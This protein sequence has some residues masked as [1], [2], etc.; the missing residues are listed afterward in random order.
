MI[1][2]EQMYACEIR[3]PW[4]FTEVAERDY[5]WLFHN[6]DNPLSH[7]SNHAV[8]LRLDGDLDAVLADITAFYRRISVV[9]RVY[10]GFRPGEMDLLRPV[11]ERHG[12][13]FDVYDDT[14]FVLGKSS[15]ICPNP[16]VEVR[17]VR[18]TD[19]A[20]ADLLRAAEGSDRTVR[21][22]RRHLEW[23]TFHCLAGYVDGHPVTLGSFD[24]GVACSRVDN[25][26]THPECRG[27]GY[28]SALMHAMVQQY[29]EVSQ[30]PLYMWSAAPRA[31]KIYRRAGFVEFSAD[32][33]GWGA[34]LE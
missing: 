31:M 6:A 1:S 5:G 18:E 30:K 7:D 27:R 9:P 21:I 26:L 12:Y 22:L 3:F 15:S 17:R 33:P 11:L 19:D 2:L 8:I 23:D 32:R 13:R 14:Y 24:V 29:P 25:V 20:L 28:C 10:P 16:A 34:W 4:R